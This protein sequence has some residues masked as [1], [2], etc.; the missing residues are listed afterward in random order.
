MNQFDK[1]VIKFLKNKGQDQP[2]VYCL[3]V[4]MIAKEGNCFY[5]NHLLTV[6]KTNDM[7][8][9]SSYIENLQEKS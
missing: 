4:D 8:E 6:T 2:G 1:S 3:L 9:L 5:V 7:L